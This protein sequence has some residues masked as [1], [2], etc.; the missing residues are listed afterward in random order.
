M[1]YRD[2]NN[3][4]HGKNVGHVPQGRRP[5]LQLRHVYERRLPRPGLATTPPVTNSRRYPGVTP[6][7]RGRPGQ[8][9]STLRGA[10]LG[11]RHAAV[12]V[13]VAATASREGEDAA[14]VT[15]WLLLTAV[16][17]RRGLQL[18]SAGGQGGR[19]YG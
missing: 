18:F 9:R 5:S 17:R 2:G 10:G 8:E 3:P 11:R 12:A 16:D 15:C 1:P 19:G 7:R 13:A 6:R 4:S 14:A